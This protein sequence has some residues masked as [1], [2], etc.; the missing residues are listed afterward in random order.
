[1]WL[2]LVYCQYL[3]SEWADLG[4]WVRLYLAYYCC[5]SKYGSVESLI[6]VCGRKIVKKE[7]DKST[8]VLREDNYK[9]IIPSANA[10]EEAINYI[11]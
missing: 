4:L 8:D 1:V 3:C 11:K 10:P 5:C 9:N 6:N 7:E 2:C